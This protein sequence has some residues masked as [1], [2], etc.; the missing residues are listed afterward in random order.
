[1]IIA[2]APCF[3]CLTTVTTNASALFIVHGDR[4]TIRF[5]NSA[6]PFTG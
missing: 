2:H 5:S 3:I 1:M 4:E 6:D